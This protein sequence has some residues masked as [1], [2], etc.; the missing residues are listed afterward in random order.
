MSH[1]PIVLFITPECESKNIFRNSFLLSAYRSTDTILAELKSKFRR[2][3]G[4]NGI[5]LATFERKRLS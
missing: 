4:I 5:S 2:K 3:V 1:A